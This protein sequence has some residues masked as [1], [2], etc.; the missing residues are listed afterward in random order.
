MKTT[1]DAETRGGWG[2]I[3]A[4]LAAMAVGLA[5]LVMAQTSPRPA[6]AA[7]DRLPDLGMANFKALQVQRTTDGRKL[8]R[9]SSILVN[10][11]DGRFEARGRRPNT[12][13]PTMAVTQRIYDDAGGY[14]SVPT[15]A[16]M[17]YS[18]ARDG[19]DGHFH[20]HVRRLEGFKL[21][22]LDNGVK[23]GTIA[24]HGF[25]FFDNYRYGSTRDPFYTIAGGACGDSSSN[26]RVR[27]GLSVGW[28]DIYRWSLPGQYID[29]TGLSAGKYRL[30]GVADPS[31]WFR[32]KDNTN[33]STWVDL[34]ITSDG[35]R[36]LN[37]GPSA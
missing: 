33:N 1:A 26:L 6:Y 14:R 9:F 16:V 27:M 28:G 21:T 30:R 7:S 32:E 10:V 24:K 19:D 31:D 20:W 17:Y 12:G 15:D 36:V 5:V 18:G 11:G 23:V 35:V 2:W 8:L 3:V 29:I 13:T 25:C 34:Q 37:H 4:L 22:R